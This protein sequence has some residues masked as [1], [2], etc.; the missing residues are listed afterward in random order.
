VFYHEDGKTGEWLK[1][2]PDLEINLPKSH[3]TYFFPNGRRYIELEVI[4]SFPNR[5]VKF[6]NKDDRLIRTLHYKLDLIIN[7]KYENGYYKG[8]F[9][10]LGQ[11][12]S[13]GLI[14]NDMM[15]GKWKFYRKE[16]NSLKQIVEY[17]NDTLHG[18]RE[19]YWNNGKLKTMLNNEKGK[20]NGKAK[21]YYATGEIEETNFLKDGKLHGISIRSYP[22]GKLESI[23]DYWLGE[24]RDTCKYYYKNGNLQKLAIINLDTATLTS[25]GIVYRYFESG[26]LKKILESKNDNVHGKGKIYYKNGNLKQEFNTVNNIKSGKVITYYETGELWIDGFAK[27]DVHHGQIKFYDKKGK[28]KKTIIAENGIAVDSIIY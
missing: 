10:N 2:N 16:D 1:I 12:Q 15:Q 23:C 27:N 5:I 21:H 7:K 4:D 13:E 9:S 11:L 6:F 26:E 3:S 17:R 28:L 24:S 22:N 18:I 25:S 19:D 14:K 8:Y 20:Q